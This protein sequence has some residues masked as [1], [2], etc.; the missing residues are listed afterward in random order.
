MRNQSDLDKKIHAYVDGLFSGV[1]ESQQLYDLKEELAT[2]LKE[3][4]ADYK[5]AGMDESTAFKEAVS[6]MGDL[7]G[8][9]DD[10][11]EVGQD[12]AKQAV[13]SSM[14][15]RIAVA[16]LITGILLILFGVLTT[17][18]L[19]FMGLQLEAVTGT[20]IF[21]VFGIAIITYSALTR[22]TSKKYAMNKIRAIFYA[23][24]IGLIAFS[25][26][27]AFTS[28]FAT[29]EMYIAISSFMIFFIIGL[30][31]WLGLLFTGTD[32]RKMVSR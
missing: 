14:T 26:Y 1:G 9:V 4:I 5:K 11:R 24:A 22:E 3:K 32:R 27:V 12:K 2:N 7:S 10:M 18:M 13:Y 19:F 23:V 17:A 29:G 16:G 8:L 21:T 20:A 15:E 6:S 28:G 31:L 25:L 30:G